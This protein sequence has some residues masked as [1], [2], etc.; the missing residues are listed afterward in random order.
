MDEDRKPEKQERDANDV[1]R[2]YVES[3]GIDDES[4]QT[5][6]EWYEQAQYDTKVPPEAVVAGGD[7]DAAWDQADAG[8]ETVGGTTPTP[9]QD[10]VDEIGRAVGVD[11]QDSEPLQPTE[12]LE[13][14]DEKRW[15]L[16]PA[17]SEDFS[18]RNQNYDAPPASQT[19]DDRSKQPPSSGK[20]RKP[21]AA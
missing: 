19:G 15:E 12:K 4:K 5:S 20:R 13:R 1:I 2:D 16:H 6:M 17:S 7:I 11:Y 18:E 8:E 3:Y 14:R 21:K 9:D 10:I